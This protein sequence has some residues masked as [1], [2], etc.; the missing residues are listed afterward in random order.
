M[1]WDEGSFSCQKVYLISKKKEPSRAKNE[2][3]AQFRT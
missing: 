2:P 1:G 3:T